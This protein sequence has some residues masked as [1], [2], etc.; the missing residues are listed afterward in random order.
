MDFGRNFVVIMCTSR[1]IRYF[2]S[3]SGSRPPYLIFFSLWRRPV[4]TFVPLYCPMQKICGFRCNFIYIP[5]AMSGLSVSGSTSAIFFRLNSLQIVHRAMLVS[6]AVTS[7]SS[8]TSAAT[9]N[10]L[11]KVIYT[12]RFHGHQVYHI[13][14][15][16]HPL[17]LHF[18]WRNSTFSKISTSFHQALMV[19]GIR[20]SAIEILDGQLSYSR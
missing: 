2:L 5:S 6:A 20:G 8:K 15:K 10:L 11:Q 17:H 14:I 13:F 9:F 16:I 7:A 1:E 19:L 4:L 12:L 3:T 18:R